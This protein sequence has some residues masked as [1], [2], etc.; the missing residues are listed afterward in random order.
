MVASFPEVR[1]DLETLGELWKDQDPRDIRHAREHPEQ[2]LEDLV[3]DAGKRLKY[4]RRG[5]RHSHL[6]G[7]EAASEEEQFS[8]QELILQRASN[9][10]DRSA[11]FSEYLAFAAAVDSPGVE[12]FR[13]KVLGGKLL[14]PEQAHALVESPAAMYFPV[15]WFKR[16]RIP[17]V[18]H[19]ATFE[20]LAEK[21]DKE[22]PY[23]L[24]RV[25][26][27]PPGITR[28]TRYRPLVDGHS[29]LEDIPTI[30]FP[31]RSG[32]PNVLRPVR[33]RSVLDELREVSGELS[34]LCPPWEE[35][36]AAW[37]TLTD[38]F[39]LV[40][41]LTGNVDVTNNSVVN[42]GTITLHVEPWIPA[43]SVREAYQDLQKQV[44]RQKN[45]P[46]FER[47]LAVFRFVVRELRS[48][49]PRDEMWRLH[50][51]KAPSWRILC[52][53]WNHQVQQEEWRYEDV[54][55]FRRAFVRGI[56]LIVRAD[57]N[58]A[59]LPKARTTS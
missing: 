22:G 4:W 29:R 49:I 13:R 59:A 8:S 1:G 15:S 44:L 36:Q 47:N 30:R 5:L 28:L 50:S 38:E 55:H 40:S 41:A 37:F 9:E 46:I 33:R 11:A 23:R 53:R 56:S 43:N 3:T 57:Y 19:A 32:K 7:L 17:V 18:G 39:P 54:R 45:R 35:A 14:A 10:K 6:L 12:R 24:V 42:Y 51:V 16:F 58:T 27:D 25:R 31:H 48:L 52:D 20:T 21:F 26:V 2:G 34:A